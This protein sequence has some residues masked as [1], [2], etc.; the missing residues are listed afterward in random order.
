MT[1]ISV[2]LRLQV[3]SLLVKPMQRAKK[4]ISVPT[5]IFNKTTMCY[6]NPLFNRNYSYYLGRK[7]K[8]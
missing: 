2:K 8:A 7:L 1:P 6:L 4:A 5:G 3:V